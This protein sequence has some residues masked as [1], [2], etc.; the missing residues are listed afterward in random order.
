MKID[1]KIE[2]NHGDKKARTDSVSMEP[3]TT[4]HLKDSTLYIDNISY[5]DKDGLSA[6]VTKKVKNM[7]YCGLGSV[8]SN[9]ISLLEWLVVFSQIGEVM[10]YHHDNMERCDSNNLWMK[11]I[12]ADLKEGTA[13]T[14]NRRVVSEITKSSLVN[15]HDD[16]WRIITAKGSDIDN[17]V[18][19]TAKIAHQLPEEK[20]K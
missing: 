14:I 5:L 6:C 8:A 1:L 13:S 2:K 18:L 12:T 17:K 20:Q 19:I 7:S 11:M 9:S 15:M 16:R 3:Y 4:G 10:T